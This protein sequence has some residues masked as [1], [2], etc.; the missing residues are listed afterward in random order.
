VLGQRLEQ[1]VAAAPVHRAHPPQ[2][3]VEF[4]ARDEVGQRQLLER[5]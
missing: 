4:A 2:V 5:G 3:P 1:R